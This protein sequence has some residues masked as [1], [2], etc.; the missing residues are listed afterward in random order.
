MHSRD[1]RTFRNWRIVGPPDAFPRSSKRIKLGER[2]KRSYARGGS[3]ACARDEPSASSGVIVYRICR[4]AHRASSGAVQQ[5][6]NSREGGGVT[7]LLSRTKDDIITVTKKTVRVSGERKRAR[8]GVSRQKCIQNRR[9]VRPRDVVPRSCQ[10]RKARWVRENDC[11]Y[12]RTRSDSC[13]TRTRRSIC[14]Q[15]S[16]IV[17]RIRRKSLAVRRRCTT[18]VGDTW[19]TGGGAL[20]R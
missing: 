12:I 10:T 18:A 4:N 16:E 15:R 19:S 5:R 1:G 9:I 20:N 11:S 13:I 3:C 2:V 14:F 6:C 7:S 8:S 17:Y